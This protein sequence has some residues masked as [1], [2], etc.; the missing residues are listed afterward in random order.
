[1]ILYMFLK[2]L[3]KKNRMSGERKKKKEEKRKE[4]RRQE[5]FPSFIVCDAFICLVSHESKLK[6][7]VAPDSEKLL[8]Q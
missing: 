4:K 7:P 8:I 1:M 5:I 6:Q 3:S 2:R